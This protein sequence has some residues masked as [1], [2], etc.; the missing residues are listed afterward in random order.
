MLNQYTNIV[1]Y[2]SCFGIID[3]ADEHLSHTGSGFSSCF[4]GNIESSFHLNGPYIIDC[5]MTRYSI[6]IE[7]LEIEKHHYLNLMLKCGIETQ[8]FCQCAHSETAKLKDD[9]IEKSISWCFPRKL[10][11]LYCNQM[12][13]NHYVESW[14]LWKL[15]ICVY[16]IC[17]IG[18]TSS[19]LIFLD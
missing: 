7:I 5:F 14:S 18:P 10:I 19:Q 3:I 8:L 4:Y 6:V 13:Q 9:Y 2:I 16:L 17:I 12:V 11:L 1:F 15:L